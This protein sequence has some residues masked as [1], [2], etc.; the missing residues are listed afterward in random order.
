MSALA[1]SSAELELLHR[2]PDGGL[3]S[4][5]RDG[6]RTEAVHQLVGQDVREERLERDVGLL[7]RGRG[8]R[9]RSASGSSSNFASCTFF[10]MTRLLPFSA[11]TRSSL[12]RLKAAVCTPA[13]ASPPMT[14]SIHDPDR[15]HGAELRV[16]VGGSIGRLFSISCRWAENSASLCG[17]LVVPQGDEGLERRL[18]IEELVHVD[19]VRTDGR[20]DRAVEVHPGDV[21]LVVVVA[22]G[23]RPRAVCRNRFGAG[24][25]GQRGRLAQQRRLLGR[26][27]RA[28]SRAVRDGVERR[29]PASA[30]DR[31]EEPCCPLA[32]RLPAAWRPSVSNSSLRHVFRIVVRHRRACR[33]APRR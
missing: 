21:A 6:V 13:R 3:L 29:C 33:R 16:P 30:A 12:G 11:V 24:V 20:L 15:R 7:R 1:S 8:Q 17:L 9:P 22:T 23:T 19:L 10:S 5:D 4:V 27:G 18:I 2:L 31:R 14:T 26:A 25:V 32:V 28:Y